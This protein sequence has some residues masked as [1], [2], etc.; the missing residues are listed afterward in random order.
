[1]VAASLRKLELGVSEKFSE[2]FFQSAKL[3]GN[4][5]LSCQSNLGKYWG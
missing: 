1:M 4:P 2:T 3:Y 5:N